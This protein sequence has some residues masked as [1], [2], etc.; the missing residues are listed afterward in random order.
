MELQNLFCTFI[1]HL[2]FIFLMWINH[3]CILG[4]SSELLFRRKTH[5]RELSTQEQYSEKTDSH[6]VWRM[7]RSAAHSH[8]VS[9]HKSKWSFLNEFPQPPLSWAVP[10]RPFCEEEKIN[11]RNFRRT[12][13]VK[14]MHF[15]A[16]WDT[17][18]FV[19]KHLCHGSHNISVHIPDWWADVRSVSLSF[20]TPNT[21]TNLSLLWL[22]WPSQP[23][24]TTHVRL[25]KCRTYLMQHQTHLTKG[26]FWGE[27]KSRLIFH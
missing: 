22:A 5:W 16:T 12:E 7:T 18:H 15:I 25:H 13:G 4:M 9:A 24:L 27:L 23:C 14:D 21:L 20:T 1:Q 3:K 10:A 6:S 19:D 8:K 26:I 2:S 11:P 17:W